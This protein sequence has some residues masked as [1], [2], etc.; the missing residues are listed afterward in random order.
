M[1]TLIIGGARSGK[2]RFAQAL[3]RDARNV[4]F[5]ATASAEC[6]DEE[7]CARI[8]RHRAER[9]HDWITIEEPLYLERVV[10][11]APPD[12]TLLID[13][14]TLWVS[15]LM[16]EHK[17]LADDERANIILRQ[18]VEFT[19]AAQERQ[20]IA[21]SNE[22]GSGI[23]PDNSVGRTFRDLQGLVNQSLARV[24]TRVVLVVAGL[25]LVLKDDRG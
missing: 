22:V 15:N 17:A 3:C 24:A 12:A 2:S 10:R 21:V 8:S 7:M 19:Q 4:L 9:P 18:V 5:I 6:A 11:E 20:V 16:W 14:I 23:V 25:P 13:C 1:L